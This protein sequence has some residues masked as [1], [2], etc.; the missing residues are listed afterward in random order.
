MIDMAHPVTDGMLDLCK[1]GMGMA[2]IHADATLHAIAG[3]LLG[4]HKLW[5]HAG[6]DDAVCKFK[7]RGVMRIYR[8]GDR[9]SGVTATGI[10]EEIGTI[11][12][13]PGYPCGFRPGVCLGVPRAFQE[14]QDRFAGCGSAGGKKCGGSVA[15]MG[16]AGFQE[17]PRCSIHEIR[18]ISA[19][20]MKI[21]KPRCHYQVGVVFMVGVMA[22][23]DPRFHRLDASV[24][25]DNVPR[26]KNPVF[27]DDLGGGIDSFI[28]E[29]GRFC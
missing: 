20:Q 13:R 21:D 19:M 5:R 12:M 8:V 3:K 28:H 14:S 29:A 11:E 24:F 4:T 1:S 16:L 17:C 9:V 15:E 23:E 26:R 2:R 7:K 27:Q 18:T 22:L 10:F 25:N 6:C